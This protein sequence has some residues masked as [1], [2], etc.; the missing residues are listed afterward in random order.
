MNLT[1]VKAKYKDMTDTLMDQI[2]KIDKVIAPLKS[3]KTTMLLYLP[4][5]GRSAISL[6]AEVLLE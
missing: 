1:E 6:L 4:Y 5:K 2:K 3:K